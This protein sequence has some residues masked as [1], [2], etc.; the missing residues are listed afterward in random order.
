MKKAYWDA[1]APKF[2]DSVFSVYKHDRAKFITKAIRRYGD[3]NKK[4]ADLGCGIGAF[5]PCIAEQ[6]G[7]V[8]AIDISPKCLKRAARQCAGYSNIDYINLDL[9]AEKIKLPKYDFGVS[10]N[11]LLSPSLESRLQF[12]DISTQ[13]L[14]NGGYF[15]LVV[16]ALESA[17][18]GNQRLIEWN[19]K[20]GMTPGRAQRSALV[21]SDGN[22]TKKVCVGTVEIDGVETKHFLKEEIIIMLEKR[23]MEILDVR[24]IEYPWHTEFVDPPAWMNAPYPWDWFVLA[25]KK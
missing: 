14:N 23:H 20:D 2:E 5:L 21:G 25:K 15:L 9:S 16:P 7:Q 1:L 18:L 17:L 8:L 19:V 3:K 10:V 12:I 22:N 4:A 6:F 11:A 24:K 13:N